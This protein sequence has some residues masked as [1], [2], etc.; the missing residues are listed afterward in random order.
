M[1][2]V[3]L[4]VEVTISLVQEAMG[5]PCTPS[6][7]QRYESF[8]GH[9]DYKAKSRVTMITC[10]NLEVD[11]RTHT[12]DKVGSYNRHGLAS[13]LERQR[14]LKVRSLFDPDPEDSGAKFL[15]S[16]VR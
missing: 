7:E 2:C 16:E 15:Q 9:G 14:D 6:N 3:R 4:C 1:L 10:L 13:W 8:Q 5:L 12:K 11:Q